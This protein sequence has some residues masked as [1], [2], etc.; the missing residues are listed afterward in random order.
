M[1]QEP[2]LPQHTE[3]EDDGVTVRFASILECG[4]A[5]TTC[6]KQRSVIFLTLGLEDASVEPL[7]F[8]LTEAKRLLCELAT[9]LGREN[10]AMGPATEPRILRLWSIPHSIRRAQLNVEGTEQKYLDQLSREIPEVAEYVTENLNSLRRSLNRAGKGAA[11]PETLLNRVKR[12]LLVAVD[13]A[14]SGT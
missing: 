2:N 14:R 1:E 13:A 6:G 10:L 5:R 9:A 4:N 11:K 7:A 3:G 8:H 12:I